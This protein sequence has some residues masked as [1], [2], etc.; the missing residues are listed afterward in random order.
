MT[1]DP[2]IERGVPLSGLTTIGTGGPATALA[3]PRTQTELEGVLHLDDRVEEA[4]PFPVEVGERDVPQAV[5]ADRHAPLR[6][7][8]QS[9]DDADLVDSPQR[10]DLRVEMVQ[11]RPVGPRRVHPSVGAHDLLAARMQVHEL[12]DVIHAP[13]D[14]EPPPGVLV[15]VQDDVGCG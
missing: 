3:R 11:H 1:A 14:D 9:P 12:C 7:E 4:H 15:V 8:L 6:P 13:F 2:T 10:I 5:G